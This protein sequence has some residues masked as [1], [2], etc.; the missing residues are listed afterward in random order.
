[1]LLCGGHSQLE[2]QMSVLGVPPM[3][4]ASFIAT[5]R[6]IGE[7]WKQSLLETM[8]EA[9]REEKKLAE[10]RGSY[11]QGVPAITV[12]VD[13]G[14]SKRLRRQARFSTWV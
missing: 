2:E 7:M 10:E 6:S 13:G 4:K 5:E 1:M 12:I 11:H 9:G 3:S 8:A 14:W